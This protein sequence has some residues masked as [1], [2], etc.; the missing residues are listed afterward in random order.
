VA[1]VRK[2][3]VA[4]AFDKCRSQRI[5]EAAAP[6]GLGQ[7]VGP[8]VRVP[9]NLEMAQLV[10]V[11]KHRIFVPANDRP[12]FY[13]RGNLGDPCDIAEEVVHSERLGKVFQVFLKVDEVSAFRS[14]D[15]VQ[16]SA[17]QVRHIAR[18]LI[19]VVSSRQ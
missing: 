11:E 14:V 4:V 16:R 17:G 13:Q 8:D 6:D 12:A 9:M 15:P 5:V 7:L 10:E 2:P 18:Q 3:A 19:V 1:D